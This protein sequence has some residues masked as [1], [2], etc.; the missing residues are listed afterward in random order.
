MQELVPAPVNVLFL[1]DESG[2]MLPH[3][4]DVRG[5]FNAYVTKLKQDGN[6]YALSVI[7]FSN[8]VAPLFVNL[9]L[10]DVPEL[11]ESSYQP[12]SGTALYDAIGETLVQARKRWG[13]K[14]HPYGIERFLV[15]IW[16]DGEENASHRFVGPE[17][18]SKIKRRQEA[19][20][21]T[22]VFLGADMDAWAAAEKLGVAPGN[23]YSYSSRHTSQTFDTLADATSGYTT[24]GAYSSR[25]FFT[26]DPNVQEA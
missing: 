4:T 11:D 19:G 12:S 20:N 21:W 26:G 2:S 25:D 15:I 24:G 17:I 5:G 13:T 14:E 8:T 9:P 22:F 16:T 10:Q 23:A 7:K 6:V 18:I 3:A 1:L